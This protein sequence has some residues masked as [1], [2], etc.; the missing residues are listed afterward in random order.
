MLLIVADELLSVYPVKERAFLLR[1]RPVARNNQLFPIQL[2]LI[3]VDRLAV[4]KERPENAVHNDRILMA[5]T[6][7]LLIITMTGFSWRR[8]ISF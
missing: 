5:E 1:G 2:S 8:R 6:D 7:Q 4:R 3:R